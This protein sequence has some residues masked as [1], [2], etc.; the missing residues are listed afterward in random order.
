MHRHNVRLC[1]T[2]NFLAQLQEGA[3]LFTTMQGTWVPDLELVLC[4]SQAVAAA[5]NVSLQCFWCVTTLVCSCTSCCNVV[6]GPS[7]QRERN[8]SQECQLAAVPVFLHS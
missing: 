7:V 6:Y 5:V 2:P 4:P 1:C 8:N 3:G